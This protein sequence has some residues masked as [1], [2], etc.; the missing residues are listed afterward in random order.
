MSIP[1][2]RC[3]SKSRCPPKAC[4]RRRPRKTNHLG[5]PRRPTRAKKIAFQCRWRRQIV[6]Q[7]QRATGFRSGLFNA[8]V[9]INILCFSFLISSCLI[10]FCLI[11]SCLISSCLIGFC[12]ISSCLIGFRPIGFCPISFRHGACSRRQGR[13]RAFSL[14]LGGAKLSALHSR[15]VRLP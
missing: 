15:G 4:R 5:R 7:S 3:P 10:S 1:K 11:S 2:S 9:F 12:L 6:F 14:P 13:R 8:N